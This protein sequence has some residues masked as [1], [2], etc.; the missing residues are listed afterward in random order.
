MKLKTIASSIALCVS[1]IGVIVSSSIAAEDPDPSNAETLSQV[2]MNPDLVNFTQEIDLTYFKE[3]WQLQVGK[4]LQK[5]FVGDS[6]APYQ[7]VHLKC[8]AFKRP[9]DQQTASPADQVD[10]RII[11]D[12][13]SSDG[14]IFNLEGRGV[15]IFDARAANIVVHEALGEAIESLT[16][17]VRSQ[18]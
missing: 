11:A 9:S 10:L 14:E 4:A 13:R 6:D 2:S 17:K 12:I 1:L 5:V 18:L 16:N 3:P 15:E 8:E 7:I